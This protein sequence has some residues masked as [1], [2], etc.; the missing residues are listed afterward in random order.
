MKKLL[1]IGHEYHLRTRSTEFL[2]ELFKR[3]YDVV[4]LALD[5][6][7]EDNS[8]RM[9]CILDRHFDLVVC[10]QVMPS[11]RMLKRYITFDRF[12]FFPM[13]DYYIAVKPI[14]D[15]IWQ[16]YADCAI[17][18]FSQKVYME[19]KAAGFSVSY[20]QY[21]PEPRPGSE[22]NGDPQ[23]LF[24]WQRVTHINLW[25]VYQLLKDYPYRRIHFHKA[26]DPN[27][28]TI[29]PFP[30]I[31]AG[32]EITESSWFDTREQMQEC[33][34]ECAIYMAP[35]P[36]E[37]IGMSF[38][39]AMS[40][41]RCVIAENQT[42][43]NEY[44]VH[45]ETGFLYDR[46]DRM[47]SLLL[48]DPDQVR[49]IQRNTMEYMRNGYEKWKVEREA[50]VQKCMDKL[51]IDVEKL[52]ETAAKYNWPI[53]DS[54]CMDGKPKVTV[55]TIVY[56]AIKNGRRQFLLDN[57]ES[58]HG[59]DYNNI[60]HLFVDGAST[61]GTVELLQKY[62]DKGWIR[63]ISEPDNGIYDAMNK[64]I[65][66]ATGKYIAFLNSDDFW[67]NK[68]GVSL[69][70][71]ALEMSG[72]DYS[73]APS[74]TTWHEIPIQK[75]HTSIGSV[76]FRMPFCHQTMFAT[77]TSLLTEGGF[78]SKNFKSAADYNLIQRLCISR[79][80]G[81]FVPTN[82]T[83]YR[84]GGFSASD[85]EIS[86]IECK[87][88]ILMVLSKLDPSFSSSDADDVFL[89]H[90]MRT[91]LYEKILHELSPDLRQAFENLP[92]KQDGEFSVF[93]VPE[94]SKAVSSC[95]IDSSYPRIKYRKI[96]LKMMGIPLVRYVRDLSGVEIKVLGVVVY[97]RKVKS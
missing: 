93:D 46:A 32:H 23:S 60:E 86:S 56:N 66:N 12:V 82:F 35:R 10:L 94:Y 19:L 90:R 4:A 1:Y 55:I 15:P 17:I 71:A 80:R 76:F 61:D 95:E 74:Y 2:I 3:Y 18:S 29:E 65:K 30:E 50:M 85:H 54:P 7:G 64:G 44:I 77:R 96:V 59:Q 34:N 69:S 62:A 22:L 26:I 70:V 73:Y 31:C 87:K 9:S 91:E 47:Q 53:Y 27:E 33:M 14:S 13:A 68:S 45:G 43:M 5:P 83:A 42:T 57:I 11:V 40:F 89:R 21:F 88:S 49:R 52:S 79:Y 75:V 8:A 92:R 41:G 39:E 28:Q 16:E 72:A 67:Y 63:L 81:V 36:L 37:G 6:S 84:H 58:V 20:Y 38:L 25:T 78:D 51:D 24:F 48:K 97:T